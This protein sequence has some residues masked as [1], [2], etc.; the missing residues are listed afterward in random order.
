MK[1]KALY[2][3]VIRFL[4]EEKVSLTRRSEWPAMSRTEENIAKVH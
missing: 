4:R 2:K 3:E 1:K